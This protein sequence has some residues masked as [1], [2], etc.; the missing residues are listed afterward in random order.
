MC[1][2]HRG[3]F[4]RI[5]FLLN[6]STA[7]PRGSWRVRPVFASGVWILASCWGIFVNSRVE[8][9]SNYCSSTALAADDNGDLS[10]VHDLRFESIADLIRLMDSPRPLPPDS[11]E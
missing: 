4:C 1:A 11:G 9:I 10:T 6:S 3:L 7:R 8:T 2:F 5:G